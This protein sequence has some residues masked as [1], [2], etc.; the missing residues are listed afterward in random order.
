MEEKKVFNKLNKA[1]LIILIVLII[2]LIFTAIFFTLKEIRINR[3]R[4]MGDDVEGTEEI[5]ELKNKYKNSSNE[6]NSTS[7]N[8][9]VEENNIII[10][11]T[12]L[13]DISGINITD[14][15]I[16][17]DDGGIPGNSYQ[18]VFNEEYEADIDITHFSSIPPFQS[19][20]ET[21]T[22]KLDSQEISKLK[23]IISKC[24]TYKESDEKSQGF[25]IIDKVNNKIYVID[26]YNKDSFTKETE[27]LLQL[28][29]FSNNFLE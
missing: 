27:T 24:D 15:E 29:I 19:T 11:R 6:Q 12:N 21:K 20:K 1:L 10:T 23:N 2:F 5:V 9:T 28:F 22:K 13:D 25:N 18:I 16:Y 3:E 17:Y 7:Q 4:I 26:Y 8:N 14:Y